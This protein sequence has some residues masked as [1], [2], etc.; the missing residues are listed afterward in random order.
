MTRSAGIT[1]VPEHA[2]WATGPTIGL[3]CVWTQSFTQP[4]PSEANVDWELF[5]VKTPWGEIPQARFTG[6]SHPAL[7][8]SGM[9]QSELMLES[10][11]FQS[12]W[13]QLRT[14]RFSAQWV[15]SP[16][17][18]LPRQSDW[19]WHVEHPQFRWG[20][21][22]HFQLAGRATRAPVKSGPATD[23][24]WGSWAPLESFFIDW[25]A[26]LDDITLTNVLVDKITLAGQWR[27]PQFTLQQ[28][29]GDLFGHQLE[30]TAE[31]NVATREA[32][33]RA[34]FDFDIHRIESLLTPDAQRWLSQFSWAE[35]PKVTAEARAVLPAWTNASPDW[36]TEVLP[37]LQLHGALKASEAA[38]RGV[39]ISSGQ[40]HFSFSNSVWN[41]PDFVATR[42]EGRVELAYTSDIRDH[43][44]HIQLRGQIDPL[45]LKPLFDEKAMMGFDFFQFHEPPLI[46]G[47]VWGQWR[48]TDKFGA[49]ARV[50]ATNFI[51][52]EVPIGE[53]TASVQF[54]NG[55]LSATNVMVSG[56]GPLVSVSGAGYDLATQTVYLTNA[57]ST[58]DPKL[59][60]HAIGPRTESLLSPYTFVTPPTARVKGWVEVRQGKNSDL[61]FEL[62]GGPFHFWKFTVPQ[63]SGTVLWVDE[64]V[65][66]TNLLADFYRGKLAAGLYFDCTVPRQ[67]DFNLRAHVA[68]TDLHQLMKDL[69][70]PTNRLE[71]ILSGD[72]TV[73]KAN[74]ADWG[75][76]NGF[77][78]AKLRDGFLWDMPM[79]GMFSSPAWAAAGSVA[80]RPPS[81]SPT[82]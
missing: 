59:I 73:T 78:N 43:D 32:T 82:A 29:R 14:N 46:E 8:G 21:A 5:E 65:T 33:S 57:L 64:T 63:V 20:E 13:F 56:G 1:G 47:A 58:M 16:E 3:Y 28:L 37:T 30:A 10:G 75:S 72:L 51:F 18:L 19:Q 69:S 80:Q 17:S 48:Q 7:D 50:S 31:V 77:G 67:S 42:P 62:S 27:A 9:L 26:Q 38:F 25:N 40:S 79:F 61:R 34:G 74:T 76:W 53:L 23:A 60:T 70:S 2:F 44:Y 22:R 6:S 49:V 36:R 39:T 24:A 11:V 41:L 45:A 54:T 81:P 71:G 15:H 68:D 52:R 35:P 66:I 4:M 55:F 12:S